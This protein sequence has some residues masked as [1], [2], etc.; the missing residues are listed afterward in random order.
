MIP[1][2][3]TYEYCS[4]AGS[5]LIPCEIHG[6]DDKSERFKLSYFDPLLEEEVRTWCPYEYV[7]DYTW[8]KL[9]KHFETHG[10]D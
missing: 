9:S 3:A 1:F 8:P 5:Y 6:W 2:K 10:W 4:M 7:S